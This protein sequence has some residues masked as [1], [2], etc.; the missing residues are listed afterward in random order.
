MYRGTGA[1][2]L[3]DVPGFVDFGLF[4]VFVATLYLFPPGWLLSYPIVALFRSYAYF[5]GYE[6]VRRK[7]IPE[8]GD[9]GDLSPLVLLFAGPEVVSST[10]H[11]YTHIKD[12]F[13]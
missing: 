4:G 12:W 9:A 13:F 6:F 3:R 1:T 10:T 8:G 11:T 5:A 7:F 2:L